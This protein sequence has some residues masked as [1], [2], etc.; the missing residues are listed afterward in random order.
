MGR[1]G[2]R[3]KMDLRKGKN[4][5]KVYLILKMVLNNENIIIIIIITYR[6][7]GRELLRG[8]EMTQRQLH[9]QSQPENS[10]SS[11]KLGTWKTLHSLQI[12]ECPFK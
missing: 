3:I 10:D 4:M 8:A 12:G 5:V 2:K 7:M 11:Q 1:E 6:N 9:H